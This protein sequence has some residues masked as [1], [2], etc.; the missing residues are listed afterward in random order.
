MVRMQKTLGADGN[1]KPSGVQNIR[2]QKGLKKAKTIKP[3][4]KSL[5]GPEYV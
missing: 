1:N 3:S 2:M 4:K 5:K